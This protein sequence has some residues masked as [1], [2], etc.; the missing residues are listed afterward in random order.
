MREIT[1]AILIFVVFSILCGLAYPFAITGLSRLFFAHEAG[2]SLV[3]REGSVAG[4]AL[5]GQ[6]FETG[7]YFRG[8]PS[9]VNYDA[10]NSGGT[11]FGPANRKFLEEVAERVAKT[12]GEYGL[13]PSD[14]VPSDFVLSSGSGLDPDVSL[15]AAMVQVGRVAK[16]RKVPEAA[17]ARLVQASAESSFWGD[18]AR[19]NVLRLNLALDAMG[20]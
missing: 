19:V 20:R 7:R 1:R 18:P 6:R 9:A 8:R 11:N 16:E 15:E 5:I 3:T 13:G 12:R 2:G 10:S 4:S 14:Q 17:L